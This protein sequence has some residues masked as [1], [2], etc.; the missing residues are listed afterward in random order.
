MLVLPVAA[1]FA[2]AAGE[3]RIERHRS[4][5][6]VPRH[7][8]ADFRDHARRFVPHH[9]GRNP[10][11]GRAVETMHVAAANAARAHA[12]QHVFRPDRGPLERGELQLVFG[13]T[14]ACIA[15]S[16]P[17]ASAV[18]TLESFALR[19]QRNP[20][21]YM[22][23][24]MN[25]VLPSSPNATFDVACACLQRAQ[26]LPFRREHQHAA[27]PSGKKIALLVDFHAIGCTLARLR[28]LRPIEEHFA[29]ADRAIV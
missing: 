7:V 5:G 27:G 18:G 3:Q 25:S 4:P 15:L 20:Q 8:R 9:Q 16:L 24:V 26:V 22:S 19:R 29:L 23:A 10:P 11:A 2:L 1:Q 14:S 13:S 21:T 28:Q 6:R 12:H 17:A